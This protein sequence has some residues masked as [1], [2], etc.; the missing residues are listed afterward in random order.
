[1][2][3]WTALEYCVDVSGVNNTWV[4]HAPESCGCQW[5]PSYDM[6]VLQPRQCKDMGSDARAALY[7]PQA[8]APYVSL[9]SSVGGSTGYFSATV[10]NS[11][12]TWGETAISGCQYPF[13]A[14]LIDSKDTLLTRSRRYTRYRDT[15]DHLWITTQS[16]YPHQ[17]R[18]QAIGINQ[19]CSR[20]YWIQHD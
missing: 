18:R 15:T 12:S 16:G 13:G 9:P 2:S 5:S 1:M 10:I 3:P 6:L 19:C 20:G 7:A 17:R 4:C 8:L 11:T 14:L